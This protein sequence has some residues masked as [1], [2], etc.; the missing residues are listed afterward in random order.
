MP[1]HDA[2]FLPAALSSE[3]T[4]LNEFTTKLSKVW[5][6]AHENIEKTQQKRKRF[7]DVPYQAGDK[8]LLHM[9]AIKNGEL[10]HCQAYE[11]VLRE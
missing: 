9:P 3:G 6:I 7:K 8:M 5:K 10:C 2:L 11:V 1:T 4:Y